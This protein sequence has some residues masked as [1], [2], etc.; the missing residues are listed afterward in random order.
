MKPHALRKTLWFTNIALLVAC[1]AVG[2][3]FFTKVRPATAAVTSRAPNKIPDAYVKIQKAYERERQTGLDWKPQA[4]VNSE[5]IHKYILIKKFETTEPKHWIYSGP[6]P[7]TKIK[8]KVTDKPVDVKPKG[9]E[10]LGKVTTVIYAP[11]S[12]TVVL[13]AFSGGKKSRAFGIGDWVIENSEAAKIYRLTGVEEVGEAAY[14]VNYAVFRG[15]KK[16]P[17]FTGHVPYGKG[18]VETAWPPFLRPYQAPEPAPEVV[19]APGATPEEGALAAGPSGVPGEP[20]AAGEAPEGPGATTEVVEGEEGPGE[21]G[22]EEGSTT[23]VEIASK[24]V[25]EMTIEDMQPEVIYNE[26]N[27][28]ERAVVVDDNTYRFLKSKNARSI[29]DTVKTEVAVDKRTGRTLGMRITGMKDGSAAGALKVK[30]GDILVSINGR[31]V[32][33]RSAAI[34]IVEGLNPDNIVTVVIDRNGKLLTY[35][36]DPRDPKTRRQVRYFDNLK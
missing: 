18:G 25:E 24:P 21:A 13:F 4:P 14:K 19:P 23:V 8:A 10:T 36:V 28:S 33:S 6:L 22:E 34:A 2:V 20:G 30:K 31:K 7:P 9:L 1:A 15:N 32:E 27:R 16:E 11:P 29:A 17:E 12:D 5:D 3:W 35:K 26:N